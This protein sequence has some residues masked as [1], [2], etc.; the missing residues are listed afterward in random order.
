[1]KKLLF[2]LPIILLMSCNPCKRLQR[3][4]PPQVKDSIV[5]VE[6]ITE[7]P[8]YTIPDSAYWHLE[9]VCDSDYNVLLMDYEEL[10]SGFKTDVQVKEV[11]RYRED[12]TS[13]RRLEVNLSAFTDSILVLNKTI[14][15]VRSEMKW[16]Y[17]EVEVPKKYV[18]KFY[19]YCFAFSLLVVLGCAAY[20]YMK[21]KGIKLK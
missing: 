17:V 16:D 2:L 6:T 9:F 3:K 14:E 12:K 15:K 4:C 10:N 18:P 5:Y 7:N 21:I 1:M 11:I 13:V 8:L 19:K 20:V